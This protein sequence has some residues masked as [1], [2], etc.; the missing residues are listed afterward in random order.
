VSASTLRLLAAVLVAA[1][2][3]VLVDVAHVAREP[4]RH[5]S[6]AVAS[7][8]PAPAHRVTLGR[9][10]LG[11]AIAAT[12][13]GDPAS[14]VAL[15]LV[16]CIHGNEGAGLAVARDLAATQGA[17]PHMWVVDNLNP[18]GFAAGTRQNAHGVDL[19]RNFP[20]R[21]RPPARATDQYSGTRPLSEP[22]AQIAYRLILR[23]RPRVAIWLH[24]PLDV[25]DESGG[26][27]ALERRFSQL[28][29]LPL[30]RLLRYPGSAVGWQNHAVRGST[31]FVVELP[32]GRLSAGAA[33]RLARAARILASEAAAFA[34]GGHIQEF[35][36]LDREPSSPA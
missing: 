1:T 33:A 5:R 26:N 24:Q 15:L 23:L 19:N 7:A 16:G 2:A 29:G 17:A 36:R 27:P 8:M 9:S 14:P 21:W 18:D 11:R 28:T 3:A 34:A 25:V 32:R 10:V 6:R 22:E 13:V 30:R 35:S 31:S 12:E 20:Y 4:R